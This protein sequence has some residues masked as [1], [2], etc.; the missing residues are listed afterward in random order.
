MTKPAGLRT[1]EIDSTRWGGATHITTRVFPSVFTA[2]HEHQ[3]VLVADDTVE[4]VHARVTKL[5]DD[6]Q[7]VELTLLAANRRSSQRNDEHTR[8]RPA[9]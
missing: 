9:G 6:G 2:L 1:V 8:R 4:P 7:T 3:E 5:H